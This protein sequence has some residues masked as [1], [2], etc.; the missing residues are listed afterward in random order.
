VSQEDTTTK[1][2]PRPC[3]YERNGISFGCGT[4]IMWDE[5]IKGYREVETGLAHSRQ[6]CMDL[7]VE[8]AAKPEEQER[9]KPTNE[10]HRER[11]DEY[12]KQRDENIKQAQDERLRQHNELMTAMKNLTDAINGLRKLIEILSG[13]GTGININRPGQSAGTL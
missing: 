7:R 9:V 2:K 10:K 12:T 4:M 13:A 6:R 3:Q 11:I 1:G 8:H 5:E